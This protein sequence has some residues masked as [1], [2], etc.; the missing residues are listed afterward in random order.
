[1]TSETA[2]AP[3]PTPYSCPVT[4]LPY[5]RKI[6]FI[7]TAEVTPAQAPVH[8][9]ALVQV[10]GETLGCAFAEAQV[11]LN[12]WGATTVTL[13]VDP[14]AVSPPFTT[15]G[16]PPAPG[17]NPHA[18]AGIAGH[19][20]MVPMDEY[21]EMVELPHPMTGETVEWV[22]CVVFAAEVAVVQA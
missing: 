20:F 10:D 8:V 4:G 9:A 15:D 7:D 6:T 11:S 19:I 17:W 21:W 5:A 18:P 1:M 14:D 3:S 12:R 22:R 2:P 16:P 13:Y